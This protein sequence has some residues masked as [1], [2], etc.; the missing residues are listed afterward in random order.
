MINLTKNE[1]RKPL[2]YSTAKYISITEDQYI[3]F[4]T[5]PE[6]FNQFK[7]LD[8]LLHCIVF[9]KD[10]V[11][12]EWGIPNEMVTYLCPPIANIDM[13]ES[14]CQSNDIL[15]VY[16]ILPS[17]SDDPGLSISRTIIL[18][19]NGQLNINLY[20]IAPTSV[21]SVLRAIANDHILFK[22]Y[23]DEFWE[24]FTDCNILLASES[25]A[26]N[27][28]LNQIPVIIIG[29]HGFGGLVTDDNIQNFIVSGFRGRIGGAVKERIPVASIVYEIQY[30]L[31]LLEFSYNKPF[32]L[33]SIESMNLLVKAFVEN[34]SI[35]K[36]EKIVFANQQ[37][38]DSLANK[39]DLL[40]LKP[41]LSSCVYIEEGL[42]NDDSEKLLINANINKILAVVGADEMNIINRCNGKNTIQEI[43]IKTD[44]F[45][46]EEVINFINELWQAKIILFI[47]ILDIIHK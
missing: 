46:E 30:V 28:L 24:S 43:I 6:D 4:I 29:N 8:H 5:Q 32:H 20:V 23:T 42:G 22:E 7:G 12:T 19:L 31:S 47:N 27:G 2:E 33:L 35:D 16:Y 44:L 15:R 3:I 34:G 21:I 36:V 9:S 45:E 37:L 13:P 17:A 39:Q 26:I 14:C 41:F 10:V 25:I 11:V 1:K 40:N 38:C 18:A